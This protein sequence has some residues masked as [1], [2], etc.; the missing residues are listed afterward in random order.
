MFRDDEIGSTK[1]AVKKLDE[2]T[3]ITTASLV[4]V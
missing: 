4:V 2:A 1:P 3:L